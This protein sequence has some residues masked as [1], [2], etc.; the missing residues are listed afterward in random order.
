[1]ANNWMELGLTKDEEELV[2]YGAALYKTVY[3]DTIDN[4]FT[5]AR[6][7]KILHDRHHGSGIRG[8]FTDALVQY[9][10]TARDGGPM[11]KAIRSHLSQ[12][13]ENE[14]AVR[15]WWEKVPQRM[16]RDWLSAKAIHNH[17]SKSRKPPDAP[18]KPSP[19]TAMKATNVELQEQLHKALVENKLLRSDDGGNYFT[20][21]S[22]PDQ[23][24]DS[25][26]NLLLA[27]PGKIRAVATRLNVRA[28]EIEARLKRAR[29]KRARPAAD[30]NV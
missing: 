29:P 4:I 24:A 26:A 9:G 13:L 23:I 22:A 14:A 16:K 8:G 28:K 30:R 18:R 27:S 21:E 1:V 12:L 6:S 17:W 25:V 11:N 15:A 5:I 20:A 3:L 10:F 2:R 19:Y 7:L